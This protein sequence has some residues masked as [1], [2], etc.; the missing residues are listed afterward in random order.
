MAV[1]DLE[2]NAVSPEHHHDN[3]QL[4][5]V[6]KASGPAMASCGTWLRIR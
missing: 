3:E 2:P 1:I 5:F 6:I 4:G